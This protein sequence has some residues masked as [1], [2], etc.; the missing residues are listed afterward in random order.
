MKK[1]N[2]RTV[3]IGLGF[4]SIAAFIYSF[5][6]LFNLKPE[7]VVFKPLDHTQSALMTGVGFSLL[8]IMIFYLLSLLQTVKFAKHVERMQPFPLFLIIS[9]VLS[10]IFVFSDI[11]LLNDINKQYRH[12]LSQPEWTLLFPIM[13]V[14]IIIAAVFTIAHVKGY[15]AR[16]E[17]DSVARDSNIFLIVQYVGVICGTLGLALSFLGFAFPRGWTLTIH[18]IMGGLVLIFPYALVVSAWIITKLREKDRQWYDEKQLQDMGRSALLT[19]IINSL[20]LTII[21]VT[22]IQNLGG[23]IRFQWLPL[24]LFSQITLF[25]L[26]NLFFSSHA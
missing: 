23:I 2:L 5:I 20:F 22:N 8:F 26:G 7:M 16:K 18:T 14:Q 4:L 17:V 24:H 21:F 15:L 3:N 10:M 13:G 9:G 11:A 19:L 12:G 1:I 25:S 6:V